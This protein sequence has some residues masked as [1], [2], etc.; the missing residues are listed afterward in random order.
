MGEVSRAVS[1]D[2]FRPVDQ[3]NEQLNR[4]DGTGVAGDRRSPAPARGYSWDPFEAGNTAAEVHGARSERRVAPLAAEIE[5]DAR[6]LPTWPEYLTEPTYGAAVAAWCRAEAVVELLWRW[7]AEQDPLDALASTSETTTEV[8]EFRG[9]SRSRSKGRRVESVLAQ[10]A[11][12][13]ATAARQRQRLGLD[14]LSRARLG[15]DHAA[16]RVDVVEVLTRMAEQRDQAAAAVPSAPTV[17]PPVGVDP[18]A[19]EEQ[20]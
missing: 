7:L 6:A 4:G 19:P 12:W 1:A 11:R 2:D 17:A 8:E 16:A 20:R 13:E 18:T 9:G 15:R 3:A 5:R 14:P 10:L